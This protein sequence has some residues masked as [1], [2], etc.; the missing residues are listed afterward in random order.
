MREFDVF[1]ASWF[2]LDVVR[3]S[4]D[5]TYTTD[6]VCNNRPIWKRYESLSFRS[7]KIFTG[8]CPLVEEL[9]LGRESNRYAESFDGW[10]HWSGEMSYT[11][12]VLSQLPDTFPNL[13]LLDI[14]KMIWKLSS[15][16][17]LRR[18]PRL[19]SLLS[20]FRFSHA[21]FFSAPVYSFFPFYS[22]QLGHWLARR[23]PRSAPRASCCRHSS[24]LPN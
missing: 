24:L 3:S 13:R 4:S 9:T 21:V 18:L 2:L 1:S 22:C 14:S 23:A 12:K 11:E 16:S 15:I 5:E 6:T 7:K 20:V 19:R 10:F 8:L 17:H